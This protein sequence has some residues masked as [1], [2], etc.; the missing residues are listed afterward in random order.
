MTVIDLEKQAVRDVNALLHGNA[1]ATVT[2][3]NPGGRHNIAV[4][5]DAQTEVRINGHVGYYCAGMNKQATVHIDGNA[6]PGVAEN[7]MSGKVEVSGNA[8]QYAGAT[9]H[10]GM[11][12]IRGDASSRCGISMKGVDIVVEGDVGHM[13]AFMAQTG[14]LVICGNAGDFIGDSLYEAI[15]YVRGEV[16]ELGADCVEKEMTSEHR[17]NLKRLL[18]EAGVNADPD[19]F[20]RFGSGR[21]LYNF[22]IDHADAY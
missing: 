16:G 7:M 13:S 2:V 3:D 20:R 6:G 11:L 1:P 22:N 14:H 15:I 10:G 12:V 21:N 18:D 19:D 4:G 8:S 17:D 9:A 5:V